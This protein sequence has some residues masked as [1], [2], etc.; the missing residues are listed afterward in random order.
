MARSL[1]GIVKWLCAWQCI[2]GLSPWLLACA[3]AGSGPIKLPVEVPFAMDKG[4]EVVEVEV[5]IPERQTYTFGLGFVVNPKDPNDAQRV[6]KLAGD[7]VKNNFT[8]TYDNPGVAL[9]VRL[10]IE[11]LT[12]ES[13]PFAF[14]EEVSEIP[15]Y[16][17]GSD[18]YEKRIAN[19]H[20]EGGIYRVRVMNLLAAP[21]TQGTP[22]NF[23]IRRGYFGK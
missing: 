16:A 9:K 21:A 18:T 17:W 15:R 10:E 3:T 23:H 6:F 7:G 13:S 11:S 12:E 8:G 22:I 19:V 1:L 20:L 4:G 5:L 14:H 2:L